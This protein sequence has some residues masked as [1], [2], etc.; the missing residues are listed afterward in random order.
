MRSIS[1]SGLD[2]PA[3]GRPIVR[4]AARLHWPMEEDEFDLI[5]EW[6]IRCRQLK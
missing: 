4:V 2:R 1:R 5:T 6:P 3:T